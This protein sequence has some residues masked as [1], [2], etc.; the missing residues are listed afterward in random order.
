MSIPFPFELVV[1]C[2]MF[3][4]TSVAFLYDAPYFFATQALF[5]LLC[6]LPEVPWYRYVMALC[7]LLI[8]AALQIDSVERVFFVACATFVCAE[9]LRFF[10]TYS[11]LWK[12]VIALGLIMITHS[13][14]EWTLLQFLGNLGI[15]FLISKRLS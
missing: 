10:M 2:T 8:V 6:L 9:S 4:D 5:T 11:L 15:C 13:G 14:F 7:A 1:F 12:I 3:L